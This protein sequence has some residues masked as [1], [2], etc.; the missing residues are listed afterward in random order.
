MTSTRVGH[1]CGVF[2][3]KAH[4]ERPILVVVSGSD[5][6]SLPSDDDDYQRVIGTSE[7]WDFTMPG[8]QW[9]VTGKLMNRSFQ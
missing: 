9:K 4:E 7:Y 2:R 6:L 5:S 8:S 3:S 1:A